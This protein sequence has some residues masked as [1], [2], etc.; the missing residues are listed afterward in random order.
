MFKFSIYL[1]TNKFQIKQNMKRHFTILLFCFFGTITFSQNLTIKGKIIAQSDQEPLIGANVL[2]KGTSKGAI[3]DLEGNYMIEGVNTNA[4]LEISYVGYASQEVAV[5]GREVI[6]I[7]LATSTLLDEVV[8][9]E[10]GITKEKRALGYGSQKVDGEVIRSS[11][12]QNLVNALQGKVA[13]VTINSAGGAPGAG[14]SINIRGI[15]SIS[16]GSDNQPLFVVDG[17]IISNS[18]VSGSVLPS[19]GTNAVSTSEQFMNTNRAADINS[20]DIESVNIL[21]GAAATALYGQRASNGA[22][23]ITTKKGVNGVSSINY[24]A[25]YGIQSVDKIPLQQ[26]IFSHG[27]GGIARTGTIP[28]FQQFG[29]PALAT[30]PVFENFRDFFRQGTSA[31]HSISA[32]TGNT[33]N[34]VFTSFS[35][36]N[37][38]GI[39]PNTEFRRITAKL[40]GESKISEK[41]TVGGQLNYA[42]SDGV[43]P[44]AGDKSIFS[45]LSYWSPSIDVND[46][47]RE[48]GSQKNVTAGTIDNP[49]YM[50]EVS[51][52]TNNVNRVF[53]DVNFGFKIN[54]WLSLKY[55]ATL[56]FFNDK[57][58]RVVTPD[59]DLGTQVRGFMTEGNRNASEFNSNFFIFANK[60]L[61][62]DFNLAVTAG[63]NATSQTFDEVTGRGEG[64]IAPGF[65]NIRNTSN[66]TV[67]KD[68]SLKRLVGVLAD[69]RLEYKNILFLNV[70]GR[71][72]WSST[73]PKAN[74][75]FFY[76]SV[77]LSYVLTNSIL[78]DNDLL[79]DLKIRAAYAEVGKDA[80][81]YAI[82]SYYGITPRF[83]FGTIGGFR[84]DPNIGNFDLLPE[85]TSEYEFGI[86]SSLL[87]NMV[88]LEANYFKRTSIN[89]IV[90]VPISNV[91]GFTRY[92]TNAGEIAN[93]GIELLL[94]VTPIR[95]KGLNWDISLNFTRIRN[96]VEKMPTGITEITYYDQ[97]RTALRIVEGGSIGDLYGFEW[98]KNQTGDIVIGA[99]GLPVLD[100]TKYV[101]IGNALPDWT[102]GLTNTIKWKGLSVS[103]LL[104]MRQGGDVVDLGE[105]NGIRNGIQLFTLKRN[106]ATVWNGVL[107]DGTTNTLVANVDENTYRAFSINAHHSFNIQDASWFRIRSA[108][109]SYSLPKSMLGNV[110]KSLKLGV[111]G[112]N[113]F[114]STPFRGYDPEGLAFG[115]GTNLIGFV[116]RNAPNTRS[117]N[118]NLNVGF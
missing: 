50:A 51:P 113:L 101:K 67:F 69:A 46:Y 95:S 49:R 55:Q 98:T 115:P 66:F 18:T 87:K 2:V 75:S 90:D 41:L 62:D 27:I 29:P 82:G 7:T 65:F 40:S 10:F 37:N 23:V 74:R 47:L 24:N 68:N 93:R 33:K 64:F 91:T 16:S 94:G 63:H 104:E 80:P 96:R 4:T 57:R 52:L 99:T 117:F 86:E 107:A 45:S 92:T 30:D 102:G 44:A 114:L 17:I 36:N 58:V 22:V 105:M 8:V 3:T 79:N 13:G 81:P 38:S 43:M 15:N 85:I 83:P 112:H 60:K 14:A 54:S 76:P 77:A 25:S 19:A 48:D 110:F 11:N 31:T 21:K 111:S 32:S 84:R 89:Q 5:N 73:L 88:T 34:K 72:D 97:G 61:S 70:T 20:D 118:F 108:N 53:G 9:T 56:D 71:N 42:N 109:L 106:V 59:L 100:Q 28:I 12:Q 35:F 116:G 39:V 103:A 78:Q 26:T 1:S 6:D